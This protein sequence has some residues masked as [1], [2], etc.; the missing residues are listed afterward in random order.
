[1]K[2]TIL[3][4]L[5]LLLSVGCAVR[6]QSEGVA[7]P[8]EAAPVLTM[9]VG[10]AGALEDAPVLTVP[11]K[12][13]CNRTRPGDGPALDEA[14]LNIRELPLVYPAD[15]GD[16]MVREI[17]DVLKSPSG[18]QITVHRTTPEAS[19]ADLAAWLLMSERSA[20][21]SGETAPVTVKVS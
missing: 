4:L 12:T 17:T 7:L 11:A 1:M 14:G 19:P 6:I 21:S 18:V 8:Q 13:I 9:S 16:P 20:V 2:R 10:S 3:L 15:G 5:A